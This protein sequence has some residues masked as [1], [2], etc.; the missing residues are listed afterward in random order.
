MPKICLHCF[1][2]GKVQGVW[3][4][5]STREKANELGI[6]GWAKN[7]ADGRVEVVACGEEQDVNVLKQWLHQGPPMAHVQEVTSENIPWQDI[8]DFV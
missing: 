7:L 8:N 2:I 3:F 5:A 4:R 1:V 6:T